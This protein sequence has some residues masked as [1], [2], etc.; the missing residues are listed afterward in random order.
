LCDGSTLDRPWYAYLLGLYLGDGAI[1]RHARGVFRLRVSLDDRYPLII[2]ECR[3]AIA[4]VRSV[5]PA[6]VGRVQAIGCSVVNSYWKHWPC[7]FPQHGTGRKHERPITFEWWQREIALNH[8]ERLLRG[9]IHSDGCRDLNVVNGKEYPRYQ[10]SNESD[11][12][13][14]IFIDACESLGLHWTTP[15]YKVVSISRRPDVY[16]VD[17]FI[18]PKTNPATI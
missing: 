7:V 14:G 11:D 15:T 18:G 9:L 6:H 1:S 4:V 17:A 5:T 2:D 16:A 3:K 8:P 10:F 12:I 13:R